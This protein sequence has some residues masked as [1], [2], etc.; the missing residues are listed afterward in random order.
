[1]TKRAWWQEHEV[2]GH[3]MSAARKHENAK[4]IGSG[5]QT[6]RAVPSDLLLPTRLHLLKMPQ[7]SQTAPPAGDQVVKHMSL[8]GTFQTQTTTKTDPA[9]VIL[10]LHPLADWS[11]FRPHWW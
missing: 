5:H 7:P 8:W 10:L 3:M 6:S 9:T 11:C 1:M 2:A 4:D